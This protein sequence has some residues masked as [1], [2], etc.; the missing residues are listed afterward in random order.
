MYLVRENSPK[1]KLM[2]SFISETLETILKRNQ[3]FKNT[4]FILPSQRAGVFV[5][6]ELKQKMITGFLPEIITVED[7]ISRVSEIQ[8]ADSL[9]LLFHFYTIYKQVEPLPDTFASF[10]NW[11]FTVLQDFS[12]IDQQLISASAIFVYLKDIERLKKWSV[13]GTFQETELMKHHT[14]FMERLGLYY[15]AFYTFLLENK[16]GYQGFIYREATKKID[17]FIEKNTQKNFYFMGFNALNKA[18]E[19]LFQKMLAAKNTNIF[20]DIDSLFLKENHQAGT[21]I[22]KYISEWN[23]YFKRPVQTIGNYFSTEKNIE[24]IGAAKNVTQLKQAGELLGKLPNH[25]RT[26]LVLADESLLPITLNSLPKNVEGI[27]IT[28]GYPLKDIPITSLFLKIFMLFLRQEKLQQKKSHTF[29]YKDVVQFFKETGIERLFQK[30]VGVV[31]EKLVVENELFLTQETIHSLTLS[32]E[33][34]S[35]L[36]VQAIFEPIKSVTDFLQR[37]INLIEHLKETA[38]SIEK[39]YLFRYYTLFTQL[40][41]YQTKFQY[42]EDLKT[43]QEFFNQL[44]ST[45]SLSFQGEPLQGL[46]L[47]GMLET[48]MLDFENVIITSVNEG[49]LPA[50]S[51]QNSFIPFDVKNEFG[52]PTYRE[53]DAIFSYHFFRLIQ[54]AKNIYILY[55]TEHD[56]FG[57]GEKSRF[58]LQLEQLKKGLTTKFVSP[59]IVTEKK[60]PKEISKT[61]DI[62]KRLQELATKGFSPSTITNYLY[63][64]MAFYKQKVLRITEFK[65]VEETVAANTMGTVVHDT[66]EEL[67]KPFEGVFLN[68]EAVTI[69]EKKSTEV[70]K[71]YFAIHFKNGNISSGKNR[72]IFEVANRFVTNFL[73]QEKKLVSNPENRLKIIA[74]EQ[75]LSTE[76]NVDGIPFP[77]KIGGI[78]D[79][80]DELNGTLRI[81]DYKTGKVE[82]KNLQFKAFNKLN[83]AQYHKAIQ[84][85]LYSF[86]YVKNTQF[87]FNQPL[88]AG[89]YSF[90]NLNSGFLKTNFSE[91]SRAY[92]YAVTEERLEL[93]LNEIKT[94]LLE[95]YNPEVAF[96][97]PLDLKY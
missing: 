93:F 54:R 35:R 74:T 59:K 65:E 26:A 32:L 37:I 17:N 6:N 94:I 61:D 42:F 10:S 13:K 68:I 5:K 73:K 58:I 46:Q 85:L 60:I 11:A 33:L 90:K 1:K 72:L 34:N 47:M 39:E 95:I 62:L 8:K 50:K 63:N 75:K 66:L 25:D 88:E 3:N 12:E 64:P 92:D 36:V 40:Q 2:Q 52:L 18:E 16:M 53:K 87:K 7:F 91:K 78:V 51:S 48:R 71:K 30:D 79:R 96:V 22:R 81:I 45:E 20:W 97:E 80:I 43:V 38:N 82:L 4:V 27:N 49:V 19:L 31:F 86:L 76:I 84:V 28:M 44:I 55:N 57:S 24:L 41:N 21:F 9:T 83:E 14:N 29:Y 67:Y 56:D 70:V 23:Y 15:E 77:V 69:M 89:I